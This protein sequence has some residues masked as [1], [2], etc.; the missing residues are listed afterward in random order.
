MTN[1]DL[2][3]SEQRGYDFIKAVAPLATGHRCETIGDALW[4]IAQAHQ[5]F[6]G[7]LTRR[8]PEAWRITA[9]RNSQLSGSYAFFA[10][11]ER[12]I[13]EVEKP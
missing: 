9:T 4:G 10:G 7:T 11:A 6:M 3:T 8:N 13:R 2:Q 12:A 5:G 1:D